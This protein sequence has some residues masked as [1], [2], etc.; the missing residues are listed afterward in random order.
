MQNFFKLLIL[1]YFIF[2][3]HSFAGTNI[4]DILSSHN[5]S[6]K[7][8]LISY[9][10]YTPN[11]FEEI[12]LNSFK[13]NPVTLIGQLLLPEGVGPFP[14]L[15]LQ[16]GTGNVKNKKNWYKDLSKSLLSNGIGI[17]INDSYKNRKLKGSNLTLAPRVV[18]GLFALQ[19]V[20]DH[21]KVDPNRIGIQG[22]SY[23]GMVAF[24]TAYEGLANIVDAK[25]AAHMPVYPGCDVVINHMN[26]TNAPIRMIIAELDDY[27][28]AQDCI[29]YGPKI[30]EI[31]IYE[32]VHHGFITGTG[33][34][35]FLSDVGNFNNCEPGYI[36]SDGK[37][38]YNGK[39]REGSESDILSEIWEECGSMGVH[40]GGTKVDQERLIQDTL[41]FFLGALNL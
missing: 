22:Y 31:I 2:P 17:F 30:G 34:D 27:A 33:R 39:V 5:D 35:E 19:A 37:W 32:G 24:F 18:D 3:T 4:D 7:N 40:V 23:G 20:A 14:V 41:E 15:I 8:E 26:M 36:Q 10:S 16:H 6:N 29:D 12:F 11:N 38:V 25:Y 28:L 13:E 21:P 9:T 1:I